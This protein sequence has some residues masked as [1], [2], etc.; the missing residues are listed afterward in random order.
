MSVLV[1]PEAAADRAAVRRVVAEAFGDEGLLIVELLGAL[2]AAGRSRVGLVAELDGVVVGHVQ[3]S[4]SWVD[5]R[6]ALVEVLVLSPLSVAPAAQRRGVGTALLAAAVAAARATGV[7]AV[8]LEGSPDFYAARGWERGSAH[9]FTRPSARIPDAAFQ[10]VVFDSREPWM[11][12]P[13]VYCD[14]FWALDAVG[15]RDPLLAEIERTFD[16]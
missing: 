15:L 11:T 16:S 8:F 2:D 13:L 12:G 7:P 9:G 4:Q 14:P 3:L 6:E 1:R 5:A 10:V